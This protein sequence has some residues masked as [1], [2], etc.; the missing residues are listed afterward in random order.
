MRKNVL[1]LISCKTENS[2]KEEIDISI[3]NKNGQI[4]VYYNSEEF[5]TKEARKLNSDGIKFAEENQLDKAEI[6]F[7]KAL[8]L[9]PNNPAL[10]FV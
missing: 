2:S 1:L 10:D 3:T 6:K 4:N 7:L 5:K 8:K 9:E